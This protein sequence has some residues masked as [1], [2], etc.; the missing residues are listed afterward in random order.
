VHG[1]AGK[2]AIVTGGLR[3]AFRQFR[4]QGSAGAVALTA[5]IASLA[6]GIRLHDQPA[7]PEHGGDG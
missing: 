1:L 2:V 4:A 7:G 5:S 6:G 3:S